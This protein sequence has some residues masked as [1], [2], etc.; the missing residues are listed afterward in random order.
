MKISMMIV[1][2]MV[3]FAVIG[4]FSHGV[5]NEQAKAGLQIH[6]PIRINGDS[7]FMSQASAEGW[8]G[9]GSAGNPY[10]ISGIGIDASSA[11]SGIYV[12]NTSLYFEIENVEI[13][14]VGGNSGEYFW[15]SGIVVYNVTN[16]VINN[17]N[18]SDAA[19]YG[20][21]VESVSLNIENLT[22]INNYYGGVYVNNAKNVTIESGSVK[23]ANTGSG[24]WV[25]NSRWINITNLQ[26]N[27]TYNGIYLANVS[28]GEMLSN[29]IWNC[30]YDGF[31]MYQSTNSVVISNNDIHH[32]RNMGF[33]IDSSN[34][35]EI[36]NNT[37]W[38]NSYGIYVK[39]ANDVFAGNTIFNSSSYG[40]YLL[41]SSHNTIS[42]ENISYSVYGIYF[43]GASYF[44]EVTHNKIFQNSQ[45]GIFSYRTNNNVIEENEITDNLQYGIFSQ[46]ADNWII[47]NNT[48]LRNAVGMYLTGNNISVVANDVSNNSK[49]GID[50]SFVNGAVLSNNIVGENG[51]GTT[52][53]AGVF[54]VSGANITITNN[55]IYN[56]TKF[57]IE[58]SKADNITIEN[59]SVYM[60]DL[61]GIFLYNSTNCSLI[62]N[63]A[64]GNIY[65]IELQVGSENLLSENIMNDS[66]IGVLI[67][68][69]KN[70]SVVNNTMWGHNNA[71][72][73]E[74]VDST[75]NL[76]QGNRIWGAK[77]NG[78]E[79]MLNAKDNR[80]YG[81]K[82]TNCS[83]AGIYLTNSHGNEIFS[84]NIVNCTY[85]LEMY[86]ASET[87]V[88][89]NQF[90]NLTSR[91]SYGIYISASENSTI[92]ANH[93]GNF[94]YGI[95]IANAYNNTI[96]HNF[97]LFNKVQ[98]Y[99]NG[100]NTWNLSKPVGGNYWSDYTG[101][102]DGD[103]FGDTPY[104]I[105]GGNNKDY[106]PLMHAYVPEMSM[107]S[108]LMF[109]VIILG[110]TMT[111]IKRK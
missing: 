42:Y 97:I 41:D 106:L 82:I 68:A 100:N 110:I 81:N 59:N 33:E 51:A 35:N 12:G 74:Y 37:I 31:V 72:I 1:L 18:I 13:K 99:D 20:I 30:T 11:G 34:N 101:N 77:Y 29:I 6:A 107:S 61:V 58:T 40:I 27:N 21:Y 55:E 39:N 32:N 54:I 44:N 109:V 38:N 78:I 45:Y 73:L 19:E 49:Y 2:V 103:G 23:N 10:I 86:N 60:N 93:V 104:P 75:G 43:S 96:Y 56:N 15:N 14:N 83:N 94:T 4:T 8:P 102:D 3:G 17:T 79:S 50:F 47:K 70:N 9:D 52:Y 69:S 84:N 65:D 26:I 48:L 46:N 7:D 95:Y 90:E 5:E 24:V 64:W 98:A 105:A 36:K 91:I 88:H 57:G 76:I 62:G 63:D 71:I 28:H 87:S 92:Y 85:G 108:F 80:M 22:A 66:G 89:E 53:G 111:Q 67:I 16:A 25:S